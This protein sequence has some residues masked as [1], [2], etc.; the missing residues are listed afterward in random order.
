[1]TQ[2]QSANLQRTLEQITVEDNG[3]AWNSKGQFLKIESLGSPVILEVVYDYKQH[4]NVDEKLRERIILHAP[5]LA[6]SYCMDQHESTKEFNRNPL[7]KPIAECAVQYYRAEV[8][9]DE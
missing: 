4:T 5:T 7:G 1:M 3:M 9:Q 6:N 2:T 8:P